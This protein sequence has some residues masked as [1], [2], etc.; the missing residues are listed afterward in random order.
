[1]SQGEFDKAIEDCNRALKADPHFEA[2]SIRGDAYF[3]KREFDLAIDDYRKAKRV[4]AQVAK[5]YLLRAKELAA[6]GH[7]AEAEQ[8]RERAYE[9]EPS[10]RTSAGTR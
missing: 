5:A 2:Y 9:I 3:Q 8:D 6:E 10:L 1:M 7:A 4:D